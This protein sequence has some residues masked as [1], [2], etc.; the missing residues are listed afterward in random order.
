[1]LSMSIGSKSCLIVYYN[2]ELDTHTGFIYIYKTCVCVRVC[3]CVCVCVCVC[4]V[5]QRFKSYL[6]DG[7]ETTEVNRLSGL[8]C[9]VPV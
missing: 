3:A 7:V 1:M 8:C 4:V 5:T 9:C 6:H 2:S